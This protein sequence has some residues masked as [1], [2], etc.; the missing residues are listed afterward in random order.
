MIPV[1]LDNTKC[2]NQYLLFCL[3]LKFFSYLLSD[4][5]IYYLKFL[6]SIFFLFLFYICF[7]LCVDPLN[8]YWKKSHSRRG[9]PI[10]KTYFSLNPPRKVY[11]TCIHCENHALFVKFNQWWIQSIEIDW[12]R[13]LFIIYRLWKSKIR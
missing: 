9:Y 1:H 5:S 3:N 13:L 8:Y 6:F 7:F 2:A 12:Y 10:W 4:L 11:I